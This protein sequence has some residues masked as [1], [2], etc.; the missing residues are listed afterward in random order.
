[1]PQKFL[2]L[3]LPLLALCFSNNTLAA[4]GLNLTN[5]AAGWFCVGLFVIAYAFVMLEE[6]LHLRTS[7]M[8]W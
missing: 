2:L 1:M 8:R 6:K 5:T 3:I 4:D 7:V